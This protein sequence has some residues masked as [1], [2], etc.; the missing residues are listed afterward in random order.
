MNPKPFAAL[1]HFTVPVSFM[2]PLLLPYF[3]SLRASQCRASSGP[4]A[5]Q[6]LDRSPRGGTKGYLTVQGLEPHDKRGN[7]G[8]SNTVERNR[9][10]LSVSQ[11]LELELN[12]ENTRTGA[13]CSGFRILVVR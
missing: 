1:N 8:V 12:H 7:C 9:L 11:G 13:A 5:L 3:L 10:K 2:F 4:S 6:L